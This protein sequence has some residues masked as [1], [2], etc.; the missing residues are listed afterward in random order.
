MTASPRPGPTSGAPSC[1]STRAR[2]SSGCTLSGCA[3]CWG[4][5]ACRSGGGTLS[6]PSSATGSLS[7]A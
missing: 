4:V 7:T 3:L 6:L 5:A 2:P 1:L